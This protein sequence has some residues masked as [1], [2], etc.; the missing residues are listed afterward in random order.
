MTETLS[1]HTATAFGDDGRARSHSTDLAY[2]MVPGAL[3]ENDFFD[4]DQVPRGNG[5]EC[6]VFQQQATK[7]IRI[8]DGECE[9]A[10]FQKYYRWLDVHCEVTELHHEIWDKACDDSKFPDCDPYP[11]GGLTPHPVKWYPLCH[12]MIHL[13]R[14]D[15][16][17]RQTT[18]LSLTHRC[19]ASSQSR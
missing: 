3:A 15:C 12:R 2:W 7:E 1:G 16:L 14:C 11:A 4:A 10:F 13:L 9:K 8:Q 19:A 5:R 17:V 6:V 18:A